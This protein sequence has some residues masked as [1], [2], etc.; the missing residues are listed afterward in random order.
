MGPS[1]Y[2]LGGQLLPTLHLHGKGIVKQETTVDDEA[3][4][5]V[6]NQLKEV[7]IRERLERAA[8]ERVALVK[9]RDLPAL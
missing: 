3:D 2:S 4:H 8:P 7:R 9:A 6:I 1:S 5:G